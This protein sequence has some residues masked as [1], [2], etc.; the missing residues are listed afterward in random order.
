MFLNS[1]SSK[2]VAW[3]V[4]AAALLAL[5]PAAAAATV[6]K[7]DF[8]SGNGLQLPEALIRSTIQTRVGVP[9]NPRLVNEDIKAL[10]KSGCFMDVMVSNEAEG[11]DG[12]RV[13]FK[14][15]PVPV[16]SEVAILSGTEVAN[17]EIVRKAMAKIP[18]PGVVV[19]G[20]LIVQDAHGNSR[21]IQVQPG[22]PANYDEEKLRD[23][24]VMDAGMEANLYT[25]ADDIEAIL[26]LYHKD[27]YYETLAF[28]ALSPIDTEKSSARLTYV[29]CEQPRY[30]L[31]EIDIIGMSG[32]AP[33]SQDDLREKL[34]SQPSFWAYIFNTGYMDP[35]R[36][37]TDQNIVK[38]AYID[39]GYLDY[40]LLRVED[41]NL[42]EKRR[43]TTVKLY[44][45]EGIRYTVK[46]VGVSG[47]QRFSADE[48]M[49][50]RPGVGG[51]ELPPVV[52]LKPGGFHSQA[53][54]R[55]DIE[56]LEAKY[57]SIGYADVKIEP[58]MDVDTVSHTVSLTYRIT[59]GGPSR[60]RDVI[61]TGNK[62]TQDHVIRRELSQHPGDL[63]DKGKIKADQTRLL[64]MNYFEDGQVQFTPVSTGTEGLKDLQLK[65]TDK[66]TGQFSIGGGYSIDESAMAFAEWSQSNFDLFGTD[67]GFTG[68]GQRLRVRGQVGEVT[69]SALVSFTEPWLFNRR[70]A[71]QT[72]F[73]LMDRFYDT[74]TLQTIGSDL[75]LTK[76]FIGDWRQRAGLGLH[77]NEVN[78]YSQAS[79]A[80]Q[81][82]EGDYWSNNL[83]LFF[84]RDLR[85]PSIL[86]REG[87][88]Y[89][90]GG[91][92]TTAALGSYTDWVR[93]EGQ[94]TYYQPLT[95]EK[96]MVLKLNADV[97]ATCGLS[98]DDEVLVFDRLFAG[99][100]NDLRGFK[101]RM[102]GPVDSQDEP[103][104]GMGML[105][106]NM[107][108][109][110][111]IHRYFA[112]SAFFDA[113]NVWESARDIS[114]T[115][116]NADIG[117]GIQLTN[118]Q[119]PIRLDYAFPVRTTWDHLNT[120]GRF[121]FSMYTT[122]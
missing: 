108:Y 35:E 11:A 55:K 62:K 22:G 76:Q 95:K 54:V 92:Y 86:P 82:Q 51:K 65:V 69:S 31:D 59:E 45:D 80:I 17:P 6:A 94:A 57:G 100:G 67:N 111:F 79:A 40:K 10:M 25:M 36:L 63:V 9:F 39:A 105:V 77:H 70:L 48:L 41:K 88:F 104:G 110:Y 30:K 46:S 96:D 101:W 52:S 5:S 89:K 15:I 122:F 68:A 34:V 99:G 113:G 85:N 43:W 117:I 93:G 47:C 13:E 109:M 120:S 8:V 106:A 27:G 16:V 33:F 91:T 97:S 74:Y 72:D 102:V 4:M 37:K 90:I 119:F 20:M 87:S 107:E 78:P 49:Q 66:Y 114:P 3:V 18:S 73:F 12:V 44:I 24:I 71:L 21:V 115:D 61:I 7:V 29:V 38:N 75:S 32:E 121:N 112:L 60:I 2:K 118:K 83:N 58:E 42:D 28:Y 81:A 53:T 26:N 50:P 103:L 56:A 14:L 98:S 1:N 23:K 64:N 19:D 116:L 84:Y